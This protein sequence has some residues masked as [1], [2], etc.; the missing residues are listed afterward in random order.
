MK[1]LY[2]IFLIPVLITIAAAPCMC[3]QDSL[4]LCI[5]TNPALFFENVSFGYRIPNLFAG[6]YL[7]RHFKIEIGIGRPVLI[8]NGTGTIGLLSTT[9]NRLKAVNGLYAAGALH[10]SF[11]KSKNAD[12]TR[13]TYCGIGMSW[14]LADMVLDQKIN[15]IYGPPAITNDLS[16]IRQKMRFAVLI[17]KEWRFSGGVYVQVEA[18]PGISKVDYIEQTETILNV[19][20][21]INPDL[22][23][24]LK[25]GGCFLKKS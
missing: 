24:N 25:F 20:Q 3:Q 13:R 1:N 19:T 5:K 23:L 9:E 2:S 18:G 4:E 21:R 8:G 6:I 16:A 15:F 17:G 14:C 11:R 22:M 12:Y 7:D 10:Y